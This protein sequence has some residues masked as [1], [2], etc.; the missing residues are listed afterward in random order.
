MITHREFHPFPT[1]FLT[2]KNQL[3]RGLRVV[4]LVFLIPTITA[5]KTYKQSLYDSEGIT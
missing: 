2:V 1:Y 3:R 4:F 5:T